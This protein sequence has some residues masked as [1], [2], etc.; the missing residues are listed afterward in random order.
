MGG[1]IKRYESDGTRTRA[2]EWTATL[3]QRLN[4]SATDSTCILYVEWILNDLR[5]CSTEEQQHM[6][7]SYF[8]NNHS[9]TIVNIRFSGLRDYIL[10]A[11]GSV[12]RNKEGPEFLKNFVQKHTGNNATMNTNAFFQDVQDAYA[13]HLDYFYLQQVPNLNITTS[14]P[15]TAAEFRQIINKRCTTKPPKYTQI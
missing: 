10:R 15:L 8:D 9:K 13:A 4:H 7:P 11:L 14:T 1:K 3:T 12:M 5:P 6:V 2:H